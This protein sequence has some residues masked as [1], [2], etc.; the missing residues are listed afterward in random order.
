MDSNQF[1]ELSKSMKVTAG[2][3]FNAAHYLETHDRNLTILTAMTSVYIIAI[4]IIPYFW[5]LPTKVIDNLNLVTVVLSIVI[6][7]SALLQNSRRDA[8]NAE[9]HHR[10]ALEINELRRELLVNGSSMP[11]DD[12]LKFAAK[13]SYILHK[14][15]INHSNLDYEKFMADRPDQFP[16]L[17]VFSQTQ[18]QHMLRDK[19]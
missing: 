8:V 4:T 5:K 14:Y 6:L 18:N 12:M 11:H 9:Q 19:R 10:S 13:Y 7:V 1:D 3:R 15:S 17:G 2:S 16:W